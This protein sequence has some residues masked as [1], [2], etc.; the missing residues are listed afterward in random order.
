VVIMITAHVVNG[1]GPEED[2]VAA[3]L[4]QHYVSP[5]DAIAMIAGGAPL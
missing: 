5:L 3:R 4:E 1:P 2:N